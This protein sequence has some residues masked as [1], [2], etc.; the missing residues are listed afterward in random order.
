MRNAL[1]D[2][3]LKGKLKLE[4][5]AYGDGFRVYQKAGPFEAQLKELR[6]MGVILAECENT[7]IARKTD[8]NTLFP[9][10]S[11]VPS[12]NGEIIIRGA[13]KWVVIQPKN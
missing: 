12:A 10:V 9:F 1:L 2:P 6:E 4:L 5:I 7:M 11:Y 13:D 3:R 8:K